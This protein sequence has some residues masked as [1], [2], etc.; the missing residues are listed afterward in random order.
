MDYE[1]LVAEQ[2]I[3]SGEYVKDRIYSGK[4]KGGCR[5][6]KAAALFLRCFHF[7]YILLL[8]KF[9]VQ[10]LF[11]W[12]ARKFWMRRYFRFFRI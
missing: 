5:L 3:D 10:K 11:I 9:V 4:G 1:K 2:R 8:T 6:K 7:D 12:K